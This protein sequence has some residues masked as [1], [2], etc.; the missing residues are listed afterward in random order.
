M[1]EN[2]TNKTGASKARAMDGRPVMSMTPIPPLEKARQPTAITSL[3]SNAQPQL[4][5]QE[6]PA[7][8]NAPEVVF[9]SNPRSR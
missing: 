4:P 7:I 6:T 8:H 1:T 3:P 9:S 5:K 2:K